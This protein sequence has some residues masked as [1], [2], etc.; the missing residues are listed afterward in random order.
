MLHEYACALI[1]ADGSSKGKLYVSQH[2]L[3]FAGKLFGKETRAVYAAAEIVAVE[4]SESP[5]PRP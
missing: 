2:Y 1:H 4:A 5:A 3:C